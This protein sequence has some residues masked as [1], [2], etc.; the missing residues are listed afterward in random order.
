MLFWGHSTT[1]SISGC[2]PED[3][4]SIPPGP[5]G[6]ARRFESYLGW[7]RLNGDAGSSPALCLAAQV[8]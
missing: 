4:G 8:V 5:V 3:G 7:E 2:R 1:A 6:E